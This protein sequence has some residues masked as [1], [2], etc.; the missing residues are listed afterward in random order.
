MSDPTSP[1]EEA[2]EALSPDDTDEGQVEQAMR[3]RLILGGFADDRLGYSRLSG[4]V[5]GDSSLQAGLDGDPAAGGGP[6]DLNGLLQQAQV[7][8]QSLSYIYDREQA[9][10]S[11]RQAGSGGGKGLSVPMWLKGVRNLFPQEAQEIMEQDA[12]ARYGLTEL[13][14]DPDILKKLEPSEALLKTILQFKHMMKGPVLD[15]ARR[16]VNEVVAQ[17]ADKIMKECRSALHGAIDPEQ[18]PPMRTFNNTDWRKTIQRNLKNWDTER[19]RLIA[20]R[21][22]YKHRQ[23]KKHSWNVIVAVDQSGS[24]TESLIHSSIMAAIFTTLPAVDVHL[25]LW[26]HRFVDM[27]DIAHDPLEVLMTSQMGGGTQML[28]AMQYSASLIT[29]PERTIFVLISDWYIWGEQ[30]QCLALAHEL[31]EAGVIGI[32]LSALDADARPIYDENFAKQLAGCGWFVAALTPK[33]LAEHIA[34]IIA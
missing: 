29:E 21:I 5:G 4:A 28:P 33:K 26:D 1:F 13:V 32:G 2:P 10:R 19:E 17:I 12:L 23:R 18:L 9:Q 8:D 34:K 11:H 7:M 14:T 24:M 27:S 25:V 15:E 6:S 22:F 31:H 30:K 3:W 16:I 20:D